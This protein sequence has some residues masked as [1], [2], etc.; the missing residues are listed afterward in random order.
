MK[1]VFI[2]TYGCQMNVHETEKL[3]SAFEKE[4]VLSASNPDDA[5][6]IVFNT[7]CIREGAETKVLGNLG[8]VKKLKETKPNLIVVVCGCMSQQ[9][10]VAKKLHKRCPFINIITGTYS[11]GAIPQMVKAIESGEKFILDLSVDENV[12]Q[13]VNEAVRSDNVNNFVNIMYGCNNFCTY[14]IVP[15]VKG[16]ER[17]RKLEDIVTEVQSLIDNG[18]KEIT[19]LGQNVNSYND[20]KHTF[21]D[22]LKTLSALD[23]KFWLKFMTSH[24]KDLSADVIKLIGGS[25]KLAKYIH[26]P[27]QS[28]SDGILKKMN[29]HYDVKSYLDKIRMI[30]KYVPGAG[31][32]S[33]MIVGFPTET[34]EDFCDTLKLVEEVRYNNLFMFIY[35]KR[36]GTPAA[37]MEGQVDESVKKERITRLIELQSKIAKELA[38][39][40]VGKTYEALCDGR[41]RLATAKTS[42]DRVIVFDDE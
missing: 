2:K 4:G 17:S 15:Y 9:E 22:L 32:T 3:Y 8:M 24:P 40:C 39:E 6:I 41:G 30:K 19:L 27:V 35:S 34:E 7:C 26:L 21:Y 33:D 42:D 12:P 23:G 11:L 25:D 37:I 31:L 1:K 28:G 14:C 38:D 20:G 16:R 36:N 18:V 29:R 13:G 5:D 10:E